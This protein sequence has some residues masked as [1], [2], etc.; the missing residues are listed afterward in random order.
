MDLGG[1][2]WAFPSRP[3]QRIAY[4]IYFNLDLVTLITASITLEQVIAFVTEFQ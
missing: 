4:I 1:P 2:E 3:V